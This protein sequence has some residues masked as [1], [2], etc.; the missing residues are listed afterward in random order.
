MKE[1]PCFIESRTQNYND[2]R[3][4]RNLIQT[5]KNNNLHDAIYDNIM[6]MLNNNKD[7]NYYLITDD[8][9]VK[10]INQYFDKN[11]LRAFNKL[12]LG[13][14]KGDFLRY[15]AM[16]IYGG[17]YLDLDSSITT[18]LNSFTNL[19]SEFIFF[20]D[21]NFNIQQW[22]FMVSPKNQ[23]I[24]KIIKEMV[25]R[26]NNK[27]SNIFLATGPT[28]VTDVIYNSINNTNVYNTTLF[29]SNRERYNTFIKNKY[30]MNGILFYEYDETIHFNNNFHF[31]MDNYQEEML[32]NNDKYTVT[33]NSPTPNFYKKELTYIFEEIYENNIWGNNGGEG[34]QIN[35]NK[36]T[37]VPFLKKF[38]I[39]NNIKTIVDL[40]CGYFTCGKL[41]Y[42]DLD[43]LYTGYD[44][45]NKAVENNSN[46]FS[47]S[48]YTFGWL[49]FCSNNEKLISGE[50][51]I[52]KDVLQHLSINN[53]TNL[54]DYIINSKKYKYILICNCCDQRKD[55]ADIRDGAFRQLSCEFLPLKKYN[56]RKIYNYASKEVSIIEL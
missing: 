44:I 39:D 43:I 10:L 23:L 50:L 21:G 6:F 1:I 31:R 52:L 47:S 16:Y 53:I 38:I 28:L 25:I 34:S 18:S 41:L 46:N 42:D 32:Y 36:D 5:Y 3:I 13:A 55:N 12:N 45:Y 35:Y 20:F 2:S 9:G 4:P 54:L 17:V 22:C 24:L 40:G 26:I 51:C 48:K 14:A 37:Y 49:D 56:P 19:G 30:F 27:E 33:I 15:I 29:V 11:T 7:F 8:I